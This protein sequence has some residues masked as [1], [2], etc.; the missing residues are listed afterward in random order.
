MS[1][2]RRSSL[3]FASGIGYTAIT[4]VVGF[5]AVPFLLEWLGEEVFGAY[6]ATIDWFG[7]LLLLEL[8]IAGALRPM[9]ARAL[10]QSNDDGVRSALHAGVR[11]YVGVTG[12]MIAVGVLLVAV[13]TRLV[14]VSEP[15]TDD[16][17]LGAAIVTVGFLLTPLAPFRTLAE[18]RQRGYL[19]NSLLLIQSLLTTAFAL[20]F[21]WRG[22]GIAGQMAAILL[23]MAAFDLSM[24]G[25]Q[26]RAGRDRWMTSIRRAAD[27]EAWRELWQL[28]TPTLIRQLSGRASF[29]SDRIIVAAFLGPRAVVPF[30]ITQRLADL[31]HQ[32]LQGIGMASWAALA[33]LH[34]KGDHDLFNH[35]LVQLTQL[36]TVLA[37]A[38][39]V[40]IA[41]FNERFVALWVGSTRYGGTGVTVF[42]AVHAYLLALYAL[43]SWCFGATGHIGR[44]VPMSIAVTVVNVGASIA[45]TMTIGLVGPLVGSVIS[46]GAVGLLV[47]PRLLFT[48]FHTEPTRLVVAVGIPLLVGM[49]VAF[50]AY[51]I[52]AASAPVGWIGLA[53]L[54]SLV[55]IVYLII[56]WIAVFDAEDRAAYTQALRSLRGGGAAS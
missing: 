3:T 1:R 11:A 52:Y 55:A 48:T 46:L 41:V 39:L 50:G 35:R 26:R 2:I 22:F 27:P 14:P 7:H 12:A 45:L 53:A 19:V 6:R 18:A 43:W 16:L 36:T 25:S 8:G 42:A 33:D 47:L 40:P 30:F 56:A 5:V 4:V 20:L 21:A 28:N 54:M 10:A 17:R 44:L 37:V 23:G 51:W 34:T 15:L 29:M 49:P 24:Y 9:F 31:A 13:I 32:Q 38:A